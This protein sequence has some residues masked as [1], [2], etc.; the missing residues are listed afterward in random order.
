MTKYF[1]ASVQV[2]QTKTVLVQVAAED[3]AHAIDLAKKQAQLREPGY[4]VSEVKLSLVGE[5]ELGVGSRVEHRIFG[6][7]VVEHMSP[8]EPGTLFIMRIRFDSGD[9]K[10]ICGPGTV[11]RPEGV[12]SLEKPVRP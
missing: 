12:A 9:T 11:I 5:S 8:V 10:N 6:P 4:S 3:E 2:V 1:N 7:G